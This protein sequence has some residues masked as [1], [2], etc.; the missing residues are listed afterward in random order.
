MAYYI[1][2]VLITSILIVL[3]AEIGKRNSLLAAVLASVPLISVLALIWLYIDT[4]DILRVREL[5]INILWL[6][7]P[8]LTLFITL[9]ILLDRGMG[10]YTSLFIGV[11]VMTLCYLA[12]LTIWKLLK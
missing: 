3:I 11:L 8:S 9:P 5:A 10:F 12:T 4:Q 6:I 1:V 2:K 7:I